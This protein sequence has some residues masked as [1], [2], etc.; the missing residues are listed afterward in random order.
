MSV[1][2][3]KVLPNSEIDQSTTLWSPPL[4][5]TW[6]D[7]KGRCQ[8]QCQPPMLTGGGGHADV[9][10]QCSSHSNSHFQMGKR[11]V[12]LPPKSEQRGHEMEISAEAVN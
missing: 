8:I 5:V 3:C 2:A 10:H 1:S 6:I 9:M 11:L 4:E 7:I 12:S